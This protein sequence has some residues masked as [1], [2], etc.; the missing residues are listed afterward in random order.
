MK[1]RSQ[2]KYDVPNANGDIF[3]KDVMT[4]A[5][6]EYQEKIKQGKA[7]G[8]LQ[9]KGFSKNDIDLSKVSHRID[10]MELTEDGSYEVDAIVLQ[11]PQG[12]LLQAL[13][14]NDI[15]VTTNMCSMGTVK[16]NIVQ[17]QK[18]ISI[19]ILPKEI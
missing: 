5:I 13:L 10:R 18:I 7:L 15:E 2:M 8:Q 9:Q 6:E 11:T 17:E 4:K 16:D 19:D 3:P 12:K 14:D 1:L